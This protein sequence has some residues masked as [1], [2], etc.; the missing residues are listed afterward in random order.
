MNLLVRS[1]TSGNQQQQSSS[2]GTVP[3]RQ[4]RINDR[5][6]KFPSSTR[7][8]TSFISSS[9]PPSS[10]FPVN[11]HMLF[12]LEADPPVTS[13]RVP[14]L[15]HGF[16]SSVS[17]PSSPSKTFF[18][19]WTRKGSSKKL[20]DEGQ[21]TASSPTFD[22]FEFYA[23]YGR[24]GAHPSTT[25]TPELEERRLEENLTRLSTRQPSGVTTTGSPSGL[26]NFLFRRSGPSSPPSSSARFPAG[27]VLPSSFEDSPRILHQEDHRT[28]PSDL[29]PSDSSPS[30]SSEFHSTSANIHSWSLPHR[31]QVHNNTSGNPS[32]LHRYLS[33]PETQSQSPFVVEDSTTTRMPD[34]SYSCLR[35]P[36]SMN[37][38]AFVRSGSMRN[39]SL[40]M[41]PDH[42]REED[43]EEEEQD[44]LHLIPRTD[45][46]LSSSTLPVERSGIILPSSRRIPETSVS[47]STSNT[48]D[49]DSRSRQE[50]LL[51]HERDAF[52]N[53]SLRG[54]PVV[55]GG[56]DLRFR[57]HRDLEEHPSLIHSYSLSPSLRRREHLRHEEDNEFDHGCVAP[58]FTDYDH[59][60]HIHQNH[61]SLQDDRRVAYPTTA[62]YSSRHH[63]R[64]PLEHPSSSRVLNSRHQLFHEESR[65]AL[66]PQDPYSRDCYSIRPQRDHSLPIRRRYQDSLQSYQQHARMNSGMLLAEEGAGRMSGLGSLMASHVNLFRISFIETNVYI[67][68]DVPASSSSPTHLPYSHRFN[69]KHLHGEW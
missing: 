7:T 59:H 60:H 12:D 19:P 69:N 68:Q 1:L 31:Q 26:K 29:T 66:V 23:N 58:S 50:S 27:H 65:E 8:S 64:E 48:L 3:P 55:G 54:S 47:F 43:F 39:T 57:R 18:Y 45:R 20:H 30:P 11:P 42:S 13:K 10:S 52:F 61:A 46:T 34:P 67:P 25:S 49:Y 51:R 21:S 22:Y 4:Q 37:H 9:S 32:R 17:T 40:V 33:S 62:E 15:R 35:M 53:T 6:K 41:P 14:S 24:Y 28:F 5:S 38:V 16:S 56:I 2:S 63:L 44:S 36:S